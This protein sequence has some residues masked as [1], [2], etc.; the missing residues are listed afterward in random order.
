M[1]ELQKKADFIVFWILGCL[2]VMAVGM[3]S[4]LYKMNS[5]L[6]RVA[7]ALEKNFVRVKG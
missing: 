5:N 3:T 6:C 7:D 4:A 2:I 1:Q